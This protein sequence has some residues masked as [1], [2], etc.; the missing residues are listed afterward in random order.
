M[1][2]LGFYPWLFVV[3]GGAI[4]LGIAIAY[5]VMHNRRRSISEIA[6]SERGA[7]RVYEDANREREG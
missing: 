1:T 5:G 2:E 4:I 3:L 7:Q 6:A